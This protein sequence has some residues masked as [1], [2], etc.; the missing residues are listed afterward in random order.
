MEVSCIYILLIIIICNYFIGNMIVASMMF[1]Y[2]FLT[3][4]RF[5]INVTAIT[6]LFKKTNILN[7][8]TVNKQS[9]LKLIFNKI[10]N[11]IFYDFPN[12]RVWME[13]KPIRRFFYKLSL[14]PV[15]RFLTYIVVISNCIILSLDQYPIIY[16]DFDDKVYYVN[17]V[18]HFFFI[19]E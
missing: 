6:N 10:M 17:L 9:R 16:K 7:V 19:F 8:D 11:F 15:F 14:H 3:R 2:N 4:E 18:F 12:R 1:E 5:N 13:Y